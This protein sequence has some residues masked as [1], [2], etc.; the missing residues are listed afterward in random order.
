MPQLEIKSGVNSFSYDSP[1]PHPILLVLF[2]WKLYLTG[3]LKEL[4][5]K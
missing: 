5:E 2:Y 3:I 4:Y 1:K